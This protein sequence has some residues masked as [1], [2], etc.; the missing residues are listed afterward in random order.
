MEEVNTK[1]NEPSEPLDENQEAGSSVSTQKVGEDPGV[2]VEEPSESQAE[3][4]KSEKST[5]Q[6]MVKLRRDLTTLVTNIQTAADAKECMQRTELEEA[7]RIRLE[8]LEKDVKSSQE[9]FEE[10]TRG[11]AMAKEKVI[12]QELQEALNSQQQLCSVLIEDKKKLISD[13]Q[14]ELKVRDDRYVKDLRKQAEELDLMMERM[15]DQIK[16][17]TKAYREEMAQAERVYQEENEV[18]LT[19][20]KTE[21]EQ[22][23]KELWDTEQERLIQRKNKVKDYETTIH[24]LML[25]TMDKNS[26]LLKEH[27]AKFQDLEKTCQQFKATNMVVKLKQIREKNDVAVHSIKKAQLKNKFASLREEQKQL[28]TEKNSREKDFMTRSRN[29]SEEYKRNIHQYERML[30]KMKHFATADA[31]KFKDMWL[32]L[33]AEVKQLVEKLLHIDS[34]IC[35]QHLG[36]SWERPTLDFTELS[37]S[38][39]PQI[40]AHRPTHQPAPQLLHTGQALQRIQEMTETSAVLETDADSRD[41][42]MLLQRESEAEVEEE[43]LSRETMK[44]VMELLCDEA[45]FLVEEELLKLLTPLEKEEQ[46]VVKLGYLVSSLGIE[47]E[48]LSKLAHFLLKHKQQSGDVCGES[49]DQAEASSNLTSDLIQSHHV[50]PALKSFLKQHMRESSTLQQAGSLHP[51]TWDSSAEAAYWERMGNIISED[52]VKLWEVAENTF[53][54]HLAVLTEISELVPETE[55]LRQQ[56]TE[57]RMLLQQSLNSRVSTE[58][59]VP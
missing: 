55:S 57:L 13:L 10:I 12:P 11:W 15:E 51:E 21:W 8:R 24:S 2:E 18:L 44:K 36:L 4:K 5:S 1:P 17:L 16:T 7:R 19:R 45:G 23:M 43:M 46:T 48:D 22:L 20:D 53:K 26:I 58:R 37:R 52:K 59:E 14:Q 33:D 29:L 27:N 41:M 35:E 6:K 30:K 39:Q 42:E 25:E 3:V 50:L 56:N 54:Q 49:S 31:R 32:M 28:V 40:Q 9:K 47:E 38:S 34:L